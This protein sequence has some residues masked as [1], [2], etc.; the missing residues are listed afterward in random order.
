[1]AR[2]YAVIL[3]SKGQLTLPVEV[4]RTLEL[5]RGARL[6]LIVRD[7]GAVELAKP[8]F[9][10]IADLAGIGRGHRTAVSSTD[11]REKAHTERW[12]AKQERS[13]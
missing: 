1:M 7:D 2:E 4:R 8:R 11:A 12:H 5:E 10:R 6:R 13:Q 9:Q 3:S